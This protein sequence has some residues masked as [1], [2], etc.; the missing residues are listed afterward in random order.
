MDEYSETSKEKEFWERFNAGG[1]KVP[2]TLR[3]QITL[4]SRRE[5][6]TLEQMATNLLNIHG[7]NPKRV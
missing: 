5:N 3:Q 1:Q 2:E 4:V 6:F 7:H